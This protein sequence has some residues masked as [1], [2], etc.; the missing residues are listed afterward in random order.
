MTTQ[1]V[2]FKTA[3]ELDYQDK[4]VLIVDDEPF[5]NISLTRIL[6]KLGIKNIGLAYDG[7]QALKFIEENN[8]NIRFLLMDID[9]PIMDG[10][11]AT[12]MIIEKQ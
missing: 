5:N 7:M 1:P 3:K 9:M 2:D 6:R 8:N 4:I 11:Q 12:K 10:I